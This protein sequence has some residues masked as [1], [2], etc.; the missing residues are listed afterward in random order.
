MRPA[1]GN[2]LE[3]A[4]ARMEIFRVLLEVLGEFVNLF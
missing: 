1:V 2:H 4:A 3:K